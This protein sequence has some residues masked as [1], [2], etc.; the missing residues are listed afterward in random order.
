MGNPFAI[1]SDELLKRQQG[2]NGTGEAEQPKNT[3][4][5]REAKETE[6]V[7]SSDVYSLAA[8][9]GGSMAT[10]DQR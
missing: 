3:K 1:T 10:T 6:K 8:Q 5:T 2:V 9:N 7:K 4:E